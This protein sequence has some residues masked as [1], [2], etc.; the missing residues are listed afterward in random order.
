MHVRNATSDSALQACLNDGKVIQPAVPPTLPY[1]CCLP[2]VHHTCFLTL[3]LAGGAAAG[4]DHAQLA[5]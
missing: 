4:L 1:S 3:L 2:C 5:A